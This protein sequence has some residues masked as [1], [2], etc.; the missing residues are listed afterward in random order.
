MQI[1]EISTQPELLCCNAAGVC[2]PSQQS[3][4]GQW[5]IQASTSASVELVLLPATLG[6]TGHSAMLSGC[7]LASS[8]VSQGEAGCHC[9]SQCACGEHRRQQFGRLVLVQVIY[10]LSLVDIV[11]PIQSQTAQQACW[12]ESG[13]TFHIVQGKQ[14]CSEPAVKMHVDRVCKEKAE[15]CCGDA[16]PRNC[17]HRPVHAL[18]EGKSLHQY[19]CLGQ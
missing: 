1:F 6:Q 7:I 10:A 18:P 19:V 5:S 14:E 3:H 11:L 4:R 13:L 17:G 9:K 8:V 16:A 15:C 2:T 12:E